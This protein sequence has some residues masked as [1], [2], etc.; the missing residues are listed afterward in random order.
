MVRLI[1]VFFV[2]VLAQFVV[3]GW[4]WLATGMSEH[5]MQQWRE[6]IDRLAL[7]AKR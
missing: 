3:H 1:G 4:L 5:S 7:E 2:A 6:D